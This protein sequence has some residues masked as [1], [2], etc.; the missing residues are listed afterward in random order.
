MNHDPTIN[1]NVAASPEALESDGAQPLQL[2]PE[3]YR[4]YLDEFELSEEQQN[5]L[6]ETLWHIMRTFVEIGWGLDSVQSVFSGIAENAMHE[7]SGA[8][9]EKDHFNQLAGTN[10]ESNTERSRR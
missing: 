8:L 3:K 9:Q 1:D 2:D 7:D 6:L 4:T 5:E 10:G